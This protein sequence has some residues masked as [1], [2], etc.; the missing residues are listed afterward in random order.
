VA[1]RADLRVAGRLATGGRTFV[2]LVRR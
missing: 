2:T 1:R